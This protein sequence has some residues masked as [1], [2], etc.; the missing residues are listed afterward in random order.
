[1]NSPNRQNF[2]ILEN[3]KPKLQEL[4]EK[5][6]KG[7]IGPEQV[8]KELEKLNVKYNLSTGRLLRAHKE[9]VD[10]LHFK[11]FFSHLKEIREDRP[12][13]A[14]KK[15]KELSLN[16]I[17]DKKM[18][19]Q[20][21]NLDDIQKKIITST[22]EEEKKRFEVYYLIM[23]FLS[24]RIDKNA[25]RD[26]LAELGIR[27]DHNFE[28]TIANPYIRGLEPYSVLIS[29]I[30]K[31][32]PIND[33]SGDEY[34]EYKAKFV[35]GAGSPKKMRNPLSWNETE[36]GDDLQIKVPP[37]GKKKVTRKEVKPEEREDFIY[38]SKLQK[39]S[40]PHSK[41]FFE[42]NG[43]IL[44]WN[45]TTEIMEL[46]NKPAGIF[47]QKKHFDIKDN[48]IGAQEKRGRIIE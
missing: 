38:T 48:L 32:G 15:A 25:F 26:D 2:T 16:Y 34:I 44:T 47:K 22:T 14:G 9:G 40:S 5:F 35:K 13:G 30:S 37:R 28:N 33:L 11:N 21:H 8:L 18:S 24:N 3:V 23:L 41:K 4:H 17:W 43:N 31:L 39:S 6:V 7:Q 36:T 12:Q 1:M 46:S 27:I 20:K 29:E 42:G 10:E 19:P 45:K